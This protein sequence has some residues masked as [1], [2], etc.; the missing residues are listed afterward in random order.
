M[1]ETLWWFVMGILLLASIVGL[2][3]DIEKLFPYRYHDVVEG[4]LTILSGGLLVMCI[5]VMTKKAIKTFAGKRNQT[6]GP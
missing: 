3:D 5:V 6:E 2:T 1:K 4:V